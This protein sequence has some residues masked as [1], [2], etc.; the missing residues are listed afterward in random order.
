MANKYLNQDY[1][2]LRS[3]CLMQRKLFCDPSFPAT[4]GSLGFDELGPNSNNT[5]GVEWKRPG[6]LCSKPQFI[7]SGATRTDVCQG[8]LGD[9]WLMAAIASLTIN[10][11][12]LARV[13]YPEQNFTD[14][15]AG[16]FRFQLWQYGKWE[17]VVVDDL[18][19][20]ING[21]LLFVN[22]ADQN[23]FWSALLEKAYAKV[24]GCYE[25]LSGGH[26]SEAQEDFTGGI[27]E[28]FSLNNAPSNLF[29]IVK[30]AL[31]RGSLLSTSIS[32]NYVGKER[33]TQEQLVEKHAYSITDATEVQAKHGQFKLVRLRNP[34][35]H[36]EWT[37]AWSDCSKDWSQ[38]SPEVKAKLF[39]SAEDGEFC[40]N[41]QFRVKLDIDSQGDD[42]C[43]VLIALMQKGARKAKQTVLPIGFYI[44]KYKGKQNVLLGC[45]DLQGSVARSHFSNKREVYQRFDLPLAEYF[46]IPATFEPNQEASFLLRVFSEK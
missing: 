29:D 24:N 31:S 12:I 1:E 46:I 45:E 18:L 15:Y 37:G 7:I 36:K 38:V 44:Y 14:K 40:T 42:K 22:S 23:E 4:F 32:V 3:Q 11:D 26:A 16:I 8:A 25:N 6:E 19:P 13:I 33:L 9:C 34:W 39:H 27:A 20:T 21:K 5:K 35:G 30:K 10:K 2:T 28:W 17:E 43:S 41:P